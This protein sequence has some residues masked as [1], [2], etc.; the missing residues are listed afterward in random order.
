MKRSHIIFSPKNGTFLA[1]IPNKRAI[2]VNY[3]R[4]ISGDFSGRLLTSYVFNK[5]DLKE[6]NS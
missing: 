1:Y 6:Q 4:K 2:L 5:S 3:I